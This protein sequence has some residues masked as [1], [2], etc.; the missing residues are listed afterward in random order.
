MDSTPVYA[1]IQRNKEKFFV[2]KLAFG[3]SLFEK[4][5]N[6]VYIDTKKQRKVHVLELDFGVS[7]F[8]EMIHCL[9]LL[10]K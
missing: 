6:I 8:E 9:L 3:V 2:L 7:L 4:M 10:F 5:I 1:Y